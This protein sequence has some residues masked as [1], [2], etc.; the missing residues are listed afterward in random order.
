M[1]SSPRLPEMAW[2]DHASLRAAAAVASV[3]DLTGA[4]VSSPIA[5]IF[6]APLMTS[7]ER[8][9]WDRI[10]VETHEGSDWEGQARIPLHLVSLLLRPPRRLS[11]RLEG[12]RTH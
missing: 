4:A 12:G 5:H 1:A 7:I 10:L 11:C 2:R 6:H 8:E 9:G 3:R